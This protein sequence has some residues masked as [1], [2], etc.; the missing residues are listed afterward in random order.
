MMPARKL[1][2]HFVL[3]GKDSGARL[4]FIRAKLAQFIR[5]LTADLHPVQPRVLTLQSVQFPGALPNMCGTA[6]GREGDDG[7]GG[8]GT[9]ALLGRG[10]WRH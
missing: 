7:F 6:F 5:Q 3:K 2:L 10:K 9:T 8:D 4:I 1:L